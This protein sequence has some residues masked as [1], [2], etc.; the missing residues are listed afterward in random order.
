MLTVVGIGNNQNTTPFCF[1]ES[2]LSRGVCVGE[3]EPRKMIRKRE[4]GVEEVCC[5]WE[6]IRSRIQAQLRPPTQ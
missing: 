2:D 4:E 3:G 6:L 5:K 1:L